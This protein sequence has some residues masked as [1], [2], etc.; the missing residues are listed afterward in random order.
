MVGRGHCLWKVVRQ[1]IPS[2]TNHS[3]WTGG[4]FRCFWL[5]P[6]LGT[7]EFGPGCRHTGKVDAQAKRGARCSTSAPQCNQWLWNHR[8]GV[9]HPRGSDTQRREAVHC[10]PFG[11]HSCDHRRGIPPMRCPPSGHAPHPAR[12]PDAIRHV[13]VP[14]YYGC[15][16]RGPCWVP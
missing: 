1:Q 8:R 3:I 2:T 15:G 14:A 11:F 5:P 6:Y 7:K 10:F 16:P 9:S 4:I 13:A 12:L